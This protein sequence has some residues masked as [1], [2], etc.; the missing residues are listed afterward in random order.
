MKTKTTLRP[1]YVVGLSI[2]LVTMTKMYADSVYFPS[3]SDRSFLDSNGGIK[4]TSGTGSE[5]A[6]SGSTG[7]WSTYNSGSGSVRYPSSGQF[8]TYSH[9][10]IDFQSYS[11]VPAGGSE[12]WNGASYV[13]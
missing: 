6:P 12:I 13:E 11:S 3:S 8:S 7:V 1:L 2:A 4:A 5:Y 10:V 9:Q